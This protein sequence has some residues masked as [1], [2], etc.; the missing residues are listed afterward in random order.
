MSV[1]S[2]TIQ[3]IKTKKGYSLEIHYIDVPPQNGVLHVFYVI[4]KELNENEKIEILSINTSLDG[5][6]YEEKIKPKM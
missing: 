5:N 3:N 1:F 2:F 4:K 6:V